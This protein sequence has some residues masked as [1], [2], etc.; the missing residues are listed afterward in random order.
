MICMKNF[1]R[2]SLVTLLMT[3]CGVMS[4]QVVTFDA[5][6]D[7]GSCGTGAAGPDQ[8]TKDGVTISITNGMLGNTFQY[9]VYK[10]QTMTI[11]STVGNIKK[12]VLTCTAKGNAQYGPGCFEN[13]TVGSYTYEEE[14]GTWTGDAAEFSLTAASNQVRMTKVEVY[15]GDVQKTLTISGTTPFTNST[16]VTITPS[17]E[18]FAVYYTT[19]G[20]NPA[21]NG[22]VYSGPFTL[23][24]TTTVKAVEE[25]YAGDMSAVV[26]KTFVKEDTPD[27]TTA[28]NIAAFKALGADT[29]AKL[30]LSNAQVLYVATNDVYVRD[31]SGAI[32]LYKIG[33]DFSNGQILNGS[34]TGRLAFYND[35]P[36]MAKTDNT[37]ANDITFAAGTAEPKVVTIAQ[38]KSPTYYC[39]LIK[40]EGVKITPREEGT[41][42]NH[43]AYIG[44]E[45]IQIYD[46]FKVG[47]EY[48]ADETYNVEG[49]LVPYKGAYEIYLT[50]PITGGVPPTPGPGGDI[51]VVNDIAAFKALGVETE[52]KLKL[53]NAQVLYVGTNDVYV[54]DA[55][56][57]IDFFKIGIEFSN[58]QILNGSITG[59]LAFYN[60]LPE[61][62]K[63]DNTNANDI[64][65]AA[66]TAEPK[67]VTMQQAKSP[68]YYCDLIKI[69]GVKIT[70]R[71]EGN[72]TNHYAYIGENEIQIYD[73]FKVG[74][75]YTE[76][77]T[78]DVEGIL[79]P[80]KGAY[81]IYLTQP[82]KSGT[83]P[84]PG[85]DLP[86]A[87][88]IAAFKALDDKTEAELTLN[89]AVVLYVGTN[90]VYVR[91][92]SG[93]IDFFKTGL[94]FVAGQ[95][96]N[97]TICGISTT[98]NG[99]PELTKSDNTNSNGY[100][101]TS[102]SAEP[103]NVTIAEAKNEA[104]YCDLI[105]IEGVKVMAKVEGDFTN[106]YAYN[107]EDEILIYDRFKV[108]ME[109]TEDGVYTVEGI[110]V[111][112]KGQYEI[113]LTQPLSSGV[114][115]IFPVCDNIAAF[116]AL[117]NGTEAELKLVD[118]VVLYAKDR[119]V[120]VR[121]ASG[122]IEF[123][124]LGLEF[125]NNQVLNGSIIGK[126][127][128]YQGLPELA[129]SE[130]TNADNFTA[131]EGSEPQPVVA[132][133]SQLGES[134]LCDLVR[135]ENV[136]FNTEENNTYAYAGEEKM[137]LF[138]KFKIFE[139]QL[140]VGETGN[141]NGILVIYKG[142][143]QIYPIS[144]DYSEGIQEMSATA[145]NP[146]APMYNAAGQRVGSD[147]KGLII[148]SG[149]KMLRK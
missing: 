69:Q 2:F 49:I 145:I 5:T 107:G 25:D 93:A 58:G 12:V 10:G 113:Y 53:N 27:V 59:R 141:V 144:F 15:L 146:D 111:P 47:L 110:L 48:N 32:D 4:A 22:K 132:T 90:D 30:T 14:F 134:L 92:A 17:N 117:D 142:N 41:Y 39:D 64:T 57:A 55:S 66:G 100:T 44:E 43:Y 77:G 106:I 133:I 108:G 71:E 19:D 7:L 62:A 125:E 85:V 54:R 139:N 56:G 1:L 40:I 99:L 115:P 72:Y 82:V 79:V 91:D 112:F 122:A 109:Y 116:K 74:L 38:A 137:Q 45:E 94:N 148:Q 138:D 114:G 24:E 121:D 123:Y 130:N 65:F 60:D 136:V 31:A 75:E 118:A 37:N 50:Q 88:N 61:M 73:R 120:F 52:A 3:I 147:Y 135:L 16:T 80:Y 84:G 23:T 129:K 28:A 46:R 83:D 101:S 18:D 63:T 96:M 104:L 87:A 9:R 143:Y 97:G 70:A 126:F 68:T 105:R 149:K 29:E 21:T 13:P 6:T 42:T 34:I 78:Y 95:V 103:K 86:K 35:L 26:E 127:S 119:D 11:A 89:N 98:Y 51:T 128:P 102:G 20:S 33:I 140:R 76:D 67:V 36:E 131:T 8:V 124:N 81:E